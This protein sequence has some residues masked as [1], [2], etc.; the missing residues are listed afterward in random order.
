MELKTQWW[1]E[2]KVTYDVYYKNSHYN[3]KKTTR[4]TQCAT[5]SGK[6]NAEEWARKDGL[7]DEGEALTLENAMIEMEGLVSHSYMPFLVRA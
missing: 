2:R 4:Q 6:L 3:E 7:I 1:I 5:C